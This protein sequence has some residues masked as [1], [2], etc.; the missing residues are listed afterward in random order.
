ME[1]LNFYHVGKTIPDGAIYIGRKNTQYNLE[2]SIFANPFP[3]ND[4][5]NRE[6]VL[7][8]YKKWIWKQILDGNITKEQILE[9]KD[10]NLVCYCSP[11]L[12]HGMVIKKLI[13]YIIDNEE[14]FDRRVMKNKIRKMMP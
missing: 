5:N 11:K 8:Q 1:I 10:K 9:L 7:E 3:L 6:I 12:C 2:A 13:E 14:D 4:S